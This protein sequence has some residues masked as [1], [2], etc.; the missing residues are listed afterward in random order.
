MDRDADGV[1]DFDDNCPDQFNPDQDDIDDNGVGNICQAIADNG[2]RDGDG[3]RDELDNCPDTITLDVSDMDDDAV[4]DA[5]DNCPFDINPEQRDIDMD[6][7]GDAC[8]PN[9]VVEGDRDGP[10]ILTG[11][12]ELHDG[13]QL[14]QGKGRARD[15]S[16]IVTS[17]QIAHLGDGVVRRD[18]G[19]LD[20]VRRVCKPLVEARWC[21]CSPGRLDLPL[22]RARRV[23][24]R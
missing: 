21:W 24:Y 22:D 1:L 13:L 20:G 3:I 2:D 5:C 7:I 6:T 23:G 17:A 19:P 15:S 14:H 18:D 4:G 16:F 8:D 12:R 11:Q 9:L 10:R